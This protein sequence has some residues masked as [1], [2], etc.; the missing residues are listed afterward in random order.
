MTPFIRSG[1]TRSG[2]AVRP[3][4]ALSRKGPSETTAQHAAV[5]A[6]TTTPT[7][8]HSTQSASPCPAPRPVQRDQPSWEELFGRR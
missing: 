7:P 5:T 4:R 6:T 8:T 1:R 2:R 3:L